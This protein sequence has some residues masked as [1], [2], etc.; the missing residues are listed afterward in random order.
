M[1]PRNEHNS[2]SQS[3]LQTGGR[4][5]ATA[6]TPTT[7][8]TATAESNTEGLRLKQ[9][10]GLFN[11]CAII[12]GVIVGSGIFVSP[13]GVIMESGSV[14]MSLLVWFSCGIFSLMGALCYA[15]L[16]TS[17]PKSGGDYAYIK[18]A[19]GEIPAF[20]FLWV[21][22]VIINP[23]SNAITALTFANY[24]LQPVFGQCD[25]PDAAIRMFAFLIICL[26]LFINCYN[27]SWATKTQNVF[28]VTKVIALLIIIITGFVWLGLGNTEHL[29]HPWDGTI[30]NF[31]ST[32]LAF[33]QGIYSFAGWNY[34]NFVTEELKNP[35]QNLPRA[36]Y[37]SLPAVTLIYVFCNLAYFAVLGIDGVIDSNAV[38]VSFADAYMGKFS[39]L[40]PI[41]VACSTVGS[42]NG[43]LFAASR[44]FFVGARDGQLPELLGMI[45]Y[46]LVT[47]LPS[48]IVLGVISL[49]MLCTTDLFLLINYTA[50]TEALMVAFAGASLLYLRW[51]Q[52]NL[53]RPIKL[54]LL[55]PIFFMI[56]C[57][58]L[59]IF[60]FFVSPFE[61]IIGLVITLSGIPVYFIGVYWKSKPKWFTDNW[62]KFTHFCQKLSIS[63]PEET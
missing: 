42:L 61:V 52:P 23:S 6:A 37:I 5:T 54:N 18:E 41:F 22:L 33:Y 10:I 58:F 34:L 7:D 16:G 63:V 17:I 24:V 36:I 57:L 49:I 25:I 1:M 32:S 55:I 27:V 12:I 40:M 45:N 48:L 2:E 13:K 59:I 21:S 28:T 35:Y 15:E 29:K 43:V 31:G 20:L 38:A 53:P 50:F 11:G 14:G 26:L 3:M 19:F 56:M 62:I 9:R 47:P 44:M 39:I 46:K 30:L 51:K 4:T 60:P 8:A